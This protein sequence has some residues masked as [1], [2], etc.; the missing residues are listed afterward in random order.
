MATICEIESY[1]SI[2]SLSYLLPATNTH[3]RHDENNIKE[4]QGTHNKWYPIPTFQVHQISVNEIKSW[5]TMI[6]QWSLNKVLLPLGGGIVG[7]TLRFPSWKL[8]DPPFLFAGLAPEHQFLSHG[9]Q[10]TWQGKKMGQTLAFC[11]C[12]SSSRKK[13]HRLSFLLNIGVFFY[14]SSV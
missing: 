13:K 9:K 8:D 5:T 4:Q 2:W 14:K 7:V 3:D 6:P 1:R 12:I 11:R 10:Q